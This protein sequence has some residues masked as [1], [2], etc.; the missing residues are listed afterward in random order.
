MCMCVR[1]RESVWGVSGLSYEHVFHVREG[2]SVLCACVCISDQRVRDS[3][4]GWPRVWEDV[5]KPCS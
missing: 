3:W 4:K 1:G 2:E 5:V